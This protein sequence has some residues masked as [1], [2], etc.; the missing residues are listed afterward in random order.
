MKAIRVGINGF[1]RI[2]RCTFKQLVAAEGFEVAAIND[3]SD[4]GDLAYLLEYDSV[5]GRYPRK[6]AQ[7]EGG[8]TVD[9]RRIPFFA[10]ED[11]ARIPW[12][13]L[14]IDVVIEST[15]AFRS[16]R[17][18][19]KHVEAGARK[20]LISAPSDDADA[21]IVYGVNTD[22]YDAR[23]H[24]VVSC[25]SCT[26]NCLAPVLGVLLDRFGVEHAMMTTVHAY[27]SS[28]ALMDTPVRKRRRG[29][30]AAVSIIPTTTGAARATVKVLPA[31]EGRV[32][33]LALRVPVPDGSVTDV[34]VALER[35]ATADA[36]NEALREAAGRPALRGVL[37]V[38]DEALVS[39]DVLG[40]THSS[41]VDAES[42][43]VVRGRVVK[44]IAWYDN[45]WGYAAR[46][47]DM[48][49]VVAGGGRG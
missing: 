5:H 21:T 40:D 9:D 26:T 49:R 28:Q 2:G 19:G 16:R 12:G 32:D 29:R 47:V 13:D 30:A 35:E 11:P 24:D 42:T 18:A 37:R 38:S 20:V 1:G 6:V 22:A 4:P 25:A 10:H 23:R 44:V 34:V 3:L 33:G 39:C 36:V 46:L 15:G 7:G 8:L 27:T 31:L 41:I 14:G 45:E 17:D 48:A 43:M